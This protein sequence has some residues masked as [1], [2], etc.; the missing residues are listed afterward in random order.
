MKLTLLSQAT[1]D[2][3][4]LNDIRLQFQPSRHVAPQGSLWLLW[5]IRQ[6]AG[7]L[8]TEDPTGENFLTV[9]A[10]SGPLPATVHNVRSLDWYP[11]VPEFLGVVELKIGSEGLAVDE[12]VDIGVTNWRSPAQPIDP[13]HFWLIADHEARWD[14]RPTGYK[15]YREF[16]ERTSG[17]RVRYEEL[18]EQLLHAKLHVRGEY[19]PI[20]PTNRR[21]TPG[22]F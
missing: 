9:R 5:D 20:P 13:F 1:A 2:A 21:R 14:F 3:D 11:A 4:T 10:A 19:S 17:R 22:V 12:V 15:T 8:Q 7:W 18:L 16:V 6:D